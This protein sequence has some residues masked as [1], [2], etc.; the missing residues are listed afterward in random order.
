MTSVLAYE[1]QFDPDTAASQFDSYFTANED[2]ATSTN[3]AGSTYYIIHAMRDI[4]QQDYNYSLSVPTGAV[5]YNART[6]AR[7]VVAYNPSSTTTTATVYNGGTAVQTVSLAANT[8]TV[9]YVGTTPVITSST[10]ASAM[11]QA[12][13]S[14]QITATNSPTGYTASGIACRSHTECD[15]RSYLRHADNGGNSHSH[16]SCDECKWNRNEQYRLHDLP[17]HESPCNY[18]R[19]DRPRNHRFSVHLPDRCEQ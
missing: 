16:G 11:A 1:A 6:N 19:V 17:V 3:F 2:I 5:Y 12:T 8:Q 10:T 9:A 13:Y 14:F 18:E 7:T 15:D 4:G